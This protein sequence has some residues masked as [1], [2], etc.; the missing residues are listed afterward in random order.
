[1]LIRGADRQSRFFFFFF[2]L[3]SFGNDGASVVGLYALSCCNTGPE[4]RY[5]KKPTIGTCRQVSWKPVCFLSSSNTNAAIQ[6]P[7]NS[8]YVGITRVSSKF[9]RPWCLLDPG[10]SQQPDT[11]WCMASRHQLF[12][13]TNRSVRICEKLPRFTK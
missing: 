1:M 8:R 5:P 12:L 13:E 10:I 11:R 3:W 4:S 7:G 9:S 2:L 6:I